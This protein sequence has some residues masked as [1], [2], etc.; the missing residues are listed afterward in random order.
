[1]KHDLFLQKEFNQSFPTKKIPLG[2]LIL[3]F[4]VTQ[5]HTYLSL[6]LQVHI[7]VVLHKL[8][9]GS[10]RHKSLCEHSEVF[11]FNNNRRVAQMP[12]SIKS[13]NGEDLLNQ[14]LLQHWCLVV[15]AAEKCRQWL[16]EKC[17]KTTLRN[18]VTNRFSIRIRGETL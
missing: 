3:W 11:C 9:N 17:R 5:I 16:V 7:V 13:L 8:R 15:V 4:V 2:T 18:R 1:M 10:F 14:L 12:N 6:K